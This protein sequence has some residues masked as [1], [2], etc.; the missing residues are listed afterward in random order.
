M[1]LR[2][3]HN[4]HLNIDLEKNF[5]DVKS[6]HFP[7]ALSGILFRFL[8]ML[9]L[10]KVTRS[11][12]LNMNEK[13][14]EEYN[15]HYNNIFSYVAPKH[16]IKKSRDKF[17]FPEVF[18]LYTGF[19]K[20]FFDEIENYIK[21]GSQ[22]DIDISIKKLYDN[23]NR[24]EKYYKWFEFL[25]DKTKREKEI[26]KLEQEKIYTHIDENYKSLIERLRKYTEQEDLLSKEEFQ[27]MTKILWDVF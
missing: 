25:F 21:H 19:V 9:Y 18:I 13:E 22:L 7:Y 1:A 5:N 12:S 24:I 20:T 3:N 2:N 27:E 10:V 26:D 8:P 6:G 17:D 14:K 4:K 16:V 15:E 11:Y 23:K